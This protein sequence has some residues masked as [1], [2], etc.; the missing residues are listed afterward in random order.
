MLEIHEKKDTVGYEEIIDNIDC[1]YLHI[2][3][4]INGQQ[5]NG[6]GIY[7]V[8]ENGIIIYDFNGSDMNITD[9]II[10]TILFKAMLSGINECLFEIK[11]ENKLH[12]IE[13][14]GF[15]KKNKKYIHD[16]SDFMINC[17]KCK[18]LQ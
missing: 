11:N 4:S 8:D 6:Y 13:N 16:I 10:R 15:I 5:V 12:I 14:L 9:G 17:K 1:Q 2:V 7:S 18:E 3:E